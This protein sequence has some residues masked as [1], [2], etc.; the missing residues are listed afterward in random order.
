[1]SDPLF[2]RSA[3]VR[4][5]D[6]TRESPEK[7]VWP[8]KKVDP[9]APDPFPRQE[10]RG[11]LEPAVAADGTTAAPVT[12][13]PGDLESPSD[14]A[15]RRSTGP[16]L[17]P[18]PPSRT[19]PPMSALCSL[20]AW[21]LTVE[22]DWLGLIRPPW[23]LRAAQAGW[24]AESDGEYCPSCG[25]GVGPHELD[26]ESSGAAVPKC[27]ACRAQRRPWERCVRL[28]PYHGLLRDAIHEV[29]F[30]AW[31]HLGTTLG[32]LLG[33]QLR[34]LLAEH[35]RSSPLLLVPMPTSFRR[36]VARGIDH[37]LVIARGVREVIGGT[38]TR[39]VRREHR[40]SQLD[41]PNSD[42]ARN[43]AG[44]FVP[45]ARVA[46][47]PTALVILID[48]VMTTGATMSAATRAVLAVPVGRPLRALRSEIS[49]RPVDSENQLLNGSLRP[50]IWAA[51]LGVTPVPTR[52]PALTNLPSDESA[53]VRGAD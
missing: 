8:P 26:R 33:E 13:R 28:G 45:R 32:R 53:R 51:V 52:C 15:H 3:P 14:V 24:S 35:G 2:D 47:P 7:F 31:R 43:V 48:D 38:L 21:S 49:P 6:E 42:R 22:R 27:S 39:P 25:Q 11:G 16:P 46:I 30:E 44:S 29:K 9:L 10:F 23:H 4:P 20:R 12:P 5:H 18:V 17:L 41:V 34:P 1:M 40:P 19:C 37:A 50:R 36:R